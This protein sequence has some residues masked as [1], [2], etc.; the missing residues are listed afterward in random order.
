MKFAGGSPENLKRALVL[1]SVLKISPLAIAWYDAVER[2]IHVSISWPRARG[3]AHGS[4]REN[5]N[6]SNEEEA[7][8]GYP[9]PWSAAG[10]RS[11]RRCRG[12]RSRF[13][14][15]RRLPPRTC[16]HSRPR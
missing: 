7:D 4:Q 15:S 3:A 11:P 6:P 10:S 16:M 8:L 5:T 13:G 2:R 9:P 1:T 12:R 14:T